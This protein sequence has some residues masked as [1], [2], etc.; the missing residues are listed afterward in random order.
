MGTYCI[1]GSGTDTTRRLVHGPLESGVIV[2][3]CDLPQV[4]QRI[5]DLCPFEETHTAIYPVG[6]TSL[7][8]RLL[9]QA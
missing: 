6:N 4:G 1:Q 8:Q 3:V 2:T 9:E 7:N 5:L